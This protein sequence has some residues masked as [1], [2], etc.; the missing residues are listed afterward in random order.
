MNPKVSVLI[1]V[2]NSEKYIS[3]C[4]QTVFEQTY[5]NIEV[6]IVNDATP[7]NSMSIINRLSKYYSGKGIVI[8]IIHHNSNKGIAATRNTLLNH[9]KGDYVYFIDSD[10]FIDANTIE[11]L[12]NFISNS[13]AD[14]VRC[15]YYKYINGTNTVIHHIPY[16]DKNDLLKQHIAAWNSIE[17]MWQLFIRRDF[18]ERHQLRFANGIN[19]AEDHLMILKLFF[20]ADII[21]EIKTPLYHYRADN[22]QSV[23]HTNKIAFRDSMYNAMDIAITFLKENGLYDLYQNEVLTRTFLSKQTYLL[24]R[25]HRDIN[26]YINTHPECNSY[27]KKFNYG[28]IQNLLFKLAESKHIV[29]LKT[30]CLFL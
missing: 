10:D 3:E 11:T 5:N 8:R 1:P 20:Y 7:D 4:L 16:V 25:N 27:Y 21:T 13:N 14:I 26:K 15:S 29:L 30:L 12:V 23:T 24:N 17:A 19:A 2:Y 22:E 9:A 28:L 18:I 6:I